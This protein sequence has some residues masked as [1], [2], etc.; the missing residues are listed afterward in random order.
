[1]ASVPALPGCHTQAESLDVLMQRIRIREA[2]ELRMSGKLKAR[3]LNRS[4][5]SAFSGSWSLHE[6]TSEPD[7]LNSSSQISTK[8]ASMAFD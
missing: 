2:I 5:L 4:M 3:P 7:G 1:V 8:R 6:Q